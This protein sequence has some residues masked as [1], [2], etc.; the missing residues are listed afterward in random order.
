MRVAVLRDV[1]AERLMSMERFADEIVRACQSDDDVKPRAL[2]VHTRSAL[3]SRRLHAAYA[4]T[5]RFAGYPLR[6]LALV[7]RRDTDLFHI[8]DQGYADLAAVL[9]KDRTVCLLYT[10]PSPRD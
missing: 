5:V 8:I 9:P 1:P 10:S 7:A 2:T 3:R 4:R 6:A